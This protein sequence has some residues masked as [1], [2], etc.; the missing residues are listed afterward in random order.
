VASRRIQPAPLD[1]DHGQPEAVATS[2][3]PLSPEALNDWLS[4]ATE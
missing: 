1:A 3:L 2:T 4:G